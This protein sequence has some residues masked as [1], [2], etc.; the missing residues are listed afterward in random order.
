[1]HREA[2]AIRDCFPE[3]KHLE[4][5]VL[6]VSPD[7]IPSHKRFADKYHLPFALLSDIHK[8]V[9]RSYGVI[10]KYNALGEREGWVMRISFLINLMS[11]VEKIY[12]DMKPKLQIQKVLTDLEQAQAGN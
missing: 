3:F 11:E 1:M 4:V 5:N 9:A 10:S 7:D 8:K 2:C 6:G 12:D